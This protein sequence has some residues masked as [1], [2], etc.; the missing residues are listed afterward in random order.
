VS[1]GERRERALRYAILALLAL[2][3]LAAG[4]VH[5]PVFIPLLVGCGVVGIASLLRGRRHARPPLPGRRLLLALHVLVLL[6][7]LPLP[8]ALLRL[9]SPGSFAFH[10]AMELLPLEAWRPISVSP[11]DTLR[12]LAFLSGMT[13]LAT[14]VFRELGEGRWRR[15][16]VLT[17]V[18]V[19]MVMTVVAFLQAASPEPRR[20]YGVFRP[21]WDWA[22]FGPYVN[23]N[24][25]AGY[26]VMAIPLA[27]GLALEALAV[28]RHAW[29]ARRQGWLALGGRE[30]YT[31]VRRASEVMVLVAGL[32]ASASRAGFV[33]FASACL[34]LPLVAR[35]RRG[36][37]AAVVLLVALGFAWVGL[38]GVLGGFE[39]RGIRGSRLDLW[40]DMLP[41]VA[42]FPLFGVGLNAFATAYPRYQNVWRSEWIGEAHNEYLQ[43]LLDMGLVGAALA[44]AFLVLVFRS[45]LGAARRGA[46]E[47]GIL[48]ALLGLAVHNSVD[49][50]WQIPA[51][52]ATW[53]ALA[54][55]ALR[56][57]ADVAHHAARPSP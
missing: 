31:L 38:G 18:A 17:V 15:R 41:M 12:G 40:R 54:A 36:T 32:L 16:L 47:L 45:A 13:L 19:G 2:A 25:F 35:R 10:S 50:N 7:L 6:Q 49:F 3:P 48:G 1:A 51:N 30:G 34:A 26:L 20:I 43:A 33:G 5:E 22:V 42:E 46:L 23:R 29:S 27:I 53:A 14:A 4:A 44:F 9:V 21:R 8:P 24:H 37:A 56:A 11:P 57:G 55:R 28:L 52:A 39:A